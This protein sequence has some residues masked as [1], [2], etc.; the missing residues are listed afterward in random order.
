[1][2]GK[3]SDWRNI[4]S[5]VPQ[6]SVLGP[7]LFLMSINDLDEDVKCK[8]PKFADDTK[9]ATRVNILITATRITK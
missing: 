7:I 2:N 3:F 5:G 9:I 6:I 1:M 8:I 4:S